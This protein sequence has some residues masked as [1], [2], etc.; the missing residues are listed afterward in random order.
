MV[1]GLIAGLA[2]FV[3]AASASAIELPPIL[4][5][6][7]EGTLTLGGEPFTAFGM[8]TYI[9]TYEVG[10]SGLEAGGGFLLP[11]PILHGVRFTRAAEWTTDPQ[12]CNDEFQMG[13]DPSH[14]EGLL[15]AEI[16]NGV[17]AIIERPEH[18]P[19]DHQEMYTTVTVEEGLPEGATITLTVGMT[20]EAP[21]ARGRP[22]APSAPP[23]GPTGT[24]NSPRP[25]DGM[26][27]PRGPCWTAHRRSCASRP[28]APSRCPAFCCRAPPR[29]GT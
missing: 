18:D 14:Y 12:E 21:W 28:P 16:D 25:A 24:S 8:E 26:A 4:D 23:T 9:F 11:D 10:P 13:A 2:C 27:T 6:G 3:W 22:S 29:S 5:S 7:G 20:G 1:R 19:F 17:P 15:W